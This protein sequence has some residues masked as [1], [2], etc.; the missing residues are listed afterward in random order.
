MVLERA[1]EKT[2]N[3]IILLL[4][5]ALLSSFAIFVWVLKRLLIK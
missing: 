5:P 2:I 3:D 4:T 1:P